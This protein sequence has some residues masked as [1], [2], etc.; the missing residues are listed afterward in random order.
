MTIVFQTFNHEIIQ[1]RIQTQ[2]RQKISQFN[3]VANTSFVN[4]NSIFV[5]VSQ[6]QFVSIVFVFHFKK[7]KFK[8]QSSYYEENE[9]EHI[10][11]FQNVRIEF[12]TCFN[13]FR[14]DRAKILWCMRFLKRNFQ[15]QSFIRTKN[16]KN[17]KN[18]FYD[19]FKSFLLNLVTNSMNRR[20]LVYETWKR[21]RQRSN[22]KM[23]N[24]KNELKKYEIH[25]FSFKKMHKIN[26]FF[27][28]L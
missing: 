11:W 17:L 26:F 16:E 8:N 18:I 6:T 1:L 3:I 25:L 13:Y 9:D 20:F 21:I 5:I 4:D 12:L 27:C 19:Y 10:R 28:K 15:F 14:N 22:Q 2:N 7:Q 24:F 23:S